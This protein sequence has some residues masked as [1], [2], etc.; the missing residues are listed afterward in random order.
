MS[1]NKILIFYVTILEFI[2]KFS[3]EIYVIALPSMALTFQASRSEISN[4]SSYFLIGVF[5]VQ[6]LIPI[7]NSLLYYKQM[8]IIFSIIYFIGSVLVIISSSVALLKFGIFFIGIGIGHASVLSKLLVY[9]DNQNDESKAIVGFALIAFFSTWAPACAIYIGGYIDHLLS[10]RYIFVG[11]SIIG[12]FLLFMTIRINNIPQNKNKLPLYKLLNGYLYL[13]KNKQLIIFLSGLSVLTSGPIIFY[14]N[15]IYLFKEDFKLPLFYFGHVLF[16]LVAFNLT[17][18]LISA[19]VINYITDTKLLAIYSI[20][21]FIIGITGSYFATIHYNHT[22]LLVMV[23]LYMMVLGGVISISRI[24]LFKQSNDYTSY[25]S[26]LISFSFSLI[27]A[28]ATHLN[29]KLKLVGAIS[30]SLP[31]LII[32]IIFLI[33]TYIGI[34]HHR[35][36]PT[37]N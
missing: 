28:L 6:F 11:L 25:M 34:Y 20:L 29:A 31:F 19:K 12:V 33:C 13:L 35:H 10:W 4:L 8:L 16:I 7:L 14:I 32:S 2:K 22:M 24:F 1:N 9:T 30:V 18:K 26:S 23:S 27:T 21:L 36:I 5:I 17:G 37:Y 3:H 15:G